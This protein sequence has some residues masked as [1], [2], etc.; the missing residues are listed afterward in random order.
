MKKTTLLRIVGITGVQKA[1]TG[2]EF[3][4]MEFAEVQ[5]IDGIGHILTNKQNRKRNVWNE[6]TDNREG[7]NGA[8]FAADPLF[9]SGKVN[10]LVAGEIL[11]VKTTPF[12]ITFP[13][14]S[15]G[16]EGNKLTGVIFEGEVGIDVF[17]RQLK[18][19]N[20]CV[21]TEDGELTAPSNLEVIP[22]GAGEKIIASAEDNVLEENIG[23][24]G[25]GKAKNQPVN[26][27]EQK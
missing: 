5:Y 25:G 22:G 10:D 21:V 13:D 20:A 18:R 17:N 8:Q 9:A 12:T 4:Q 26:K 23:G 27:G 11:T 15:K 2:R 6:F 19:N 7:M 1:I 3:K 14:G 24:A 16:R